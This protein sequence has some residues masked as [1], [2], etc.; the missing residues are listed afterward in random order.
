[1]KAILALRQRGVLMMGRL[2]THVLDTAHGVPA[3]GVAVALYSLSPQRRLLAEAV[4][5]ADG[6][7]DAPILDD[8]EFSTGSYELLFRAGDYFRARNTPKGSTYLKKKKNRGLEVSS[9][10]DLYLYIAMNLP[11]SPC[12]A[13]S[14]PIASG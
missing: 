2:T 3:Q 4:T 13:I 8:A 9:R 1:M 10:G 14:L 5:N 6:R 12:I 7:L 11:I